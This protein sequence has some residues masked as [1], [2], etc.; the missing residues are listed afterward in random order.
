VPLPNVRIISCF[1][2]NEFC[3]DLLQAPFRNL[4]V[5]RKLWPWSSHA[6]LSP[7]FC[8][9]GFVGRKIVTLLLYS[10][11][12]F[13]RYQSVVISWWLVV[14]GWSVLLEAIVSCTISGYQFHIFLFFSWSSIPLSSTPILL[15]LPAG[16]RGPAKVIL[17]LTLAAQK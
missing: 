8:N 7:Y 16:I 10:T 2:R 17:A 6:V 14:M 1:E 3:S 15:A 9:L 11:R 5:R 13:C 4:G 12:L